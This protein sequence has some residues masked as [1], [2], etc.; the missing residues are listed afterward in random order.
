[1]MREEHPIERARR[2]L[3]FVEAS[4]G[5]ANM[6]SQAQLEMRAFLDFMHPNMPED[7]KRKL[8]MAAE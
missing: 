4:R 3:C 2:N 6:K 8:I 1:M 7:E 5:S